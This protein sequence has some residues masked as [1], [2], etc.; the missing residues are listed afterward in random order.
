MEAKMWTIERPLLEMEQREFLLIYMMWQLNLNDIS[1]SGFLCQI[2]KFSL[3][4]ENDSKRV[5]YMYFSI[6]NISLKDLLSS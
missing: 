3:I 6:N 5:G 4:F 2:V 1:N